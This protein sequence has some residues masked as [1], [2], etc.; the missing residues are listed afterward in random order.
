MGWDNGVM[1]VS[2]R[3]KLRNRPG[4]ESPAGREEHFRSGMNNENQRRLQLAD[5]FLVC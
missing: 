1:K 5:V 2:W 4:V 3:V